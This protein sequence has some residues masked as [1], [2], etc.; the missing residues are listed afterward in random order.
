MRDR[1]SERQWTAYVLGELK[2]G[3]RQ[4]AERILA[5][6]QPARERV[7]AI[8][9]AAECLTAGLVEDPRF[10]LTDEQRSSV[11][12]RESASSSEGCSGSVVS[13]RSTLCAAAAALLHKQGQNSLKRTAEAEHFG[14][15][16]AS[17][18]TS[19]R[20]RATGARG[21]SPREHF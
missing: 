11:L 16:R 15:P 8:R 12:G 17:D 6:S 4:W 1:L 13:T 3:E 2:P 20:G 10:R 5:E 7:A 9:E 21:R 14:R 19:T 18:L